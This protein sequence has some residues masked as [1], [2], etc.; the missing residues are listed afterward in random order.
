M[1]SKEVA[2]DTCSPGAHH[3][4]VKIEAKTVDLLSANLENRQA[5][6]QGLG[7]KH[8]TKIEAQQCKISCQYCPSSEFCQDRLE[9]SA[10]LLQAVVKG[11]V[12]NGGYFRKVALREWG[13][14]GCSPS[15][16]SWEHRRLA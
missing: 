9:A 1:H 16:I 12:K 15:K 10:Q 4:M 11:G 5:S 2:I 6:L 8:G 13:L 7:P 14:L 3:G